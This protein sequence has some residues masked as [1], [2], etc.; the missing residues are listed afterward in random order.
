[1][2][3][4]I[5]PKSSFFF[6][7][8]TGVAIIAVV[9]FFVMMGMYLKQDKA[10]NTPQQVV[11][12][13]VEDN[14]PDQPVSLEAL[15]IKDTDHIRGNKNAQITIVEYSDFQCPYC[16]RFHETMKQIIT[17]YSDDVRWVYRHFPLDSIHPVA[18]KASEASECAN[19]QGKFWE[20]TDEVFVNQSG[21]SLESL[22]TIAANINLNVSKFNS[23][24]S[25]GKYSAKVNANY[26]EGIQ[27]G[28]RGTPGNFING[29]SVPGAVPYE[30][31]PAMIEDL[32]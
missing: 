30:Q 4:N 5:K 11:N 10:K 6:G 8:I 12:N 3:E 32:L 13:Q 1:M 17:N 16:L 28:V 24:L 14:Q 25:S 22:S 7:I 9:G 23:C 21:L 31:I 20:Y 2:Q 27:I 19:D 29:Q 26:K 18:R 15:E